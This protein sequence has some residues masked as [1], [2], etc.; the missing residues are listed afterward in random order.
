LKIAQLQKNTP[1]V[2]ES[3]YYPVSIGRDAFNNGKISFEKADKVC[4]I[5]KNF[6]T[7]SKEYG[8]GQ[9]KVIAT[10]AMREAENRDYILDQIRLKTGITVDVIDN[11][12]EKYYIYKMMLNM[13][14]KQMKESSMLVYIGSGNVGV[15]LVQ[16][17]K[18]PMIRKIKVGS[19]RISELF[20]HIQDYSREFYI[21]V[22]EYVGTYMNSLSGNLPFKPNY[23]ISSGNEI[24]TIAELCGAERNAGFYHIHKKNFDALY[25]DIKMKT[26]ETIMDKYHISED[27][28]EL[29]LPSMCIFNNLMQFSET[30][31]IVAPIESSLIDSVLFETLC[32]DRYEELSKNF[33]K[34]TALS[35]RVFAE[36]FE[37]NLAHCAK[38][39]KFALKIF[40]KLKKVHGLSEKE[41]V[42]LQAAS[43]L[44]DCG[45]FIGFSAHYRNS[46]HMIRS[47]DIVGLNTRDLE[48]V[49]CAA[50]Y[51]SRIIPSAQDGVYTALS[52]IDRVIVS[53]LTAILRVADALDRSQQQKFDLLDVKLDDEKLTISI[54]TDRNIDLE[55]WAFMEKSKFFEEVFGF[56]S[57]LKK[58]KVSQ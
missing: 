8:V 26:T 24:S 1:T 30:S 27:K 15:S 28:A 52:E 2:L 50:L 17:E 35:S 12:E 41:R 25:D 22:E 10:S 48:I 49:A 14:P 56:K 53:K 34:N 3:L 32:T 5:I 4:E 40:D 18:M 31:M 43:I 36:K 19:L 44:H 37:C 11:S 9:T 58:K 38:V 51:H 57:N 21:V 16:K 7:V 54:L 45:K 55:Q 33:E 47:I 42:L 6:L 29:L 39:E 23:F 46:Y 20:E 13:L